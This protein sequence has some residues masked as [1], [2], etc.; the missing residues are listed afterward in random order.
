MPNTL[1]AILDPRAAVQA[2]SHIKA[3]LWFW[4]YAKGI[5]H[6]TGRDRRFCRTCGIDIA[7]LTC[8][9]LHG[10]SP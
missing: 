8:S 1:S 6:E 10:L 2:R 5:V 7:S 3:T 4:W 9:S